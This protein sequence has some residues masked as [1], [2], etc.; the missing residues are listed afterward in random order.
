MDG[1]CDVRVCGKP[2]LV[3]FMGQMLC[4]EH[5][6]SHC[7]T[8]ID[9]CS[10]SLRGN[11]KWSASSGYTIEETLI[12]IADRTTQLSLNAPA[13]NKMEKA[14]LLDILLS[15]GALSKSLRQ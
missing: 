1:Y 11:E 13:L 14:Q 2:E 7:Y 4:S 3:R 10:D 6:I 9:A 5:F 12:E 15:L 8:Q